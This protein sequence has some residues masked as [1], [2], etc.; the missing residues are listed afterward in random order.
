MKPTPELVL[1]AGELDPDGIRAVHQRDELVGVEA[2]P[3]GP[4]PAR[5]APGRRR[6][7][8][9]AAVG[10]TRSEPA[11]PRAPSSPTRRPRGGTA[12]P[13]PE[14]S[15][16]FPPATRPRRI[17]E[18]LAR[19]PLLRPR[20]CAPPPAAVCERVRVGLAVAAADCGCGC[21]V[22]L[23]SGGFKKK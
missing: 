19:R 4:P 18:T 9:F 1:E 14:S 23:L 3:H 11:S 12:P 20:H 22:Q 10:H 13:A 15:K 21:L 2:G 5:G 16:G 17:R 7:P 8:V 6:I